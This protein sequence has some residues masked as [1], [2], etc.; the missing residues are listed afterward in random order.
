VEPTQSP[1]SAFPVPASA[2]LFSCPVSFCYVENE[3][4]W[5]E[6]VA[7]AVGLECLPSKSKALN[8][9]PRT[10]ERKRESEVVK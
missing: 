6:G 5:A 3:V 4:T 10:E 8:S 7:Q 9:N 2:I 1:T